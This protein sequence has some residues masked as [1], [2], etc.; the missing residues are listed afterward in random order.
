MAAKAVFVQGKAMT[1]LKHECGYFFIS[2]LNT[3]ASLLLLR[4]HTF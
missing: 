2:A 4:T 3:L 1:H